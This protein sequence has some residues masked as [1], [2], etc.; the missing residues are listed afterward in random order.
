M[1]LSELIYEC[2]KVSTGY[3]DPSF[4]YKSFITQEAKFNPDYSSSIV[5]VF[6]DVNSFFQR[7]STL[8]KIERL[9]RGKAKQTFAKTMAFGSRKSLPCSKSGTLALTT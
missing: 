8:G 7:L 5:R 9:T 4:T 2:V 3:G 6:P 1:K